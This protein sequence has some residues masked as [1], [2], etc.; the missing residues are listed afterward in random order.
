MLSLQAIE[1]NAK[2]HNMPN[3][4]REIL[5]SCAYYAPKN[6]PLRL[7][8]ACLKEIVNIDLHQISY[9]LDECLG[10]LAR[11]SLI[12]RNSK[13]DVVSVHCLIQEV[14]RIQLSNK[15]NII[16]ILMGS[17][18][19]TS[20]YPYGA[21]K[22]Q[23]ADY[24]IKRNLIIHLDKIKKY[25]DDYIYN[26]M[27]ASDK[28]LQKNKLEQTL[29]LWL[30]IYLADAYGSLGDVHKQKALWERVLKI[31]ESHYGKEHIDVARVLVNLGN[32]Y[33]ALGIVDK[34]KAL[35]E[36]A[37]KIQETHYGQGHIEVAVTLVNFALAY[38]ALGEARKQKEILE[39]AL[40]IVEAHNN[41][42][43]EYI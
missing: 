37:L 13:D 22:V 31:Q 23:M 9:T 34:Q 14:S 38:G 26:L 4:A 20:V 2:S 36:R 30:L 3:I 10:Q 43:Q 39:R 42:S 7:A 35:L 12:E 40:K 32:S 25:V 16:Y 17:Y 18:A 29:L 21:N 24:A 19:L 6:I 1:D 11:Y 33:G 41:N 28:Q 15:Q 5:L 27:H 8:E